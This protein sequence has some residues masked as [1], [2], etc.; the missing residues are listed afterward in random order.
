[1]CSGLPRH[2]CLH[3]VWRPALFLLSFSFALGCI[4]E[5]MASLFLWE[6][7]VNANPFSASFSHSRS[8]IVKSR[9]EGNQCSGIEKSM[10]R[11]HNKRKSSRDCRVPKCVWFLRRFAPARCA[12]FTKEREKNL[13]EQ[14]DIHNFLERKADQ[15]CQREFAAQTKL[16]EAQ[17]DLDRREVEDAECCQ[18]SLR[19]R[20]S[21]PIPEDGPL[22]NKS[23]D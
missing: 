17:S 20:Y 21:A 10:T 7:Q 4:S 14:R 11:K 22:S 1:M 5:R 8:G 15:A 18:S 19:N 9:R 23:I 12:S 2:H 6:R 16:S 13:S 3:T